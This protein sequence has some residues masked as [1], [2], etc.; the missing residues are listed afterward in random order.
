LARGILCDDVLIS[1]KIQ[2]V[3]AMKNKSSCTTAKQED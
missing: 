2:S 3:F 1:P